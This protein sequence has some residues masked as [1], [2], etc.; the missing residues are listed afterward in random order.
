[1]RGYVTCKHCKGIG[2]TFKWLIFPKSCP[3]CNGMGYIWMDSTH[4]IDE[5]YKSKDFQE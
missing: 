4:A 2:K 3:Y 5:Y 1:M